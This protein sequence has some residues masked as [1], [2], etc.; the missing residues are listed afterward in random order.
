MPDNSTR[1]T[2]ATSYRS[3][4]CF[5]HRFNGARY[6][7]LPSY[8]A[9]CW[10][11]GQQWGPI[12]RRKAHQSI[13]FHMHGL[14]PK[15]VTLCAQGD[16]YYKGRKPLYFSV[17]L[18]RT[19]CQLSKHVGRGHSLSAQLYFREDLLF[20]CFIWSW[21]FALLSWVQCRQERRGSSGHDSVYLQYVV[22]M[23]K[24]SLTEA[25]SGW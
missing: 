8:K 4:V 15:A 7:E 23:G 16:S 20:C 9:L 12:Q 14:R 24:Q 2:R 10:T 3:Y 1:Q 25:Q 17:F 6:N 11:A 19:R 22:P 5:H 21:L 18:A 13:G